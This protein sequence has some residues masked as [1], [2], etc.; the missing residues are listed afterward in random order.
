MMKNG[1]LPAVFAIAAL[2]AGCGGGG[3]T[4]ATATLWLTAVS[5]IFAAVPTKTANGM[6]DVPVTPVLITSANQTL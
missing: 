1:V 5:G 3:S 2:M 4:P 6:A